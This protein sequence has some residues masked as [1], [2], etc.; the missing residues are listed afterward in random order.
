VGTAPAAPLPSCQ[1]KQ[2]D[3]AATDGG[4]NSFFGGPGPT[5][6]FFGTSAAAPHAA[7]VAALQLDLAPGL[8]PAQVIAAQ[9]ASAR[10]VG[11][12]GPGAVGAGL[13]DAVAA[14]AAH[15]VPSAQVI[16]WTTPPPGSV[17]AG[18]SF[19]VAAAATSGLPVS[20]SSSGQCTGGGTGSATII[21]TTAGACTVRADQAGD[22]QWL[23]AA[24]L[25]ASVQV[26]DAGYVPTSPA[27]LLDSRPGSVTFDGQGGGIG[28]RPALST[29]ELQVTGRAGVPADAGAAVLNVTVT[30][31]DA[32]GFV[33]VWP[34][35]EPRPLA[36]SLNF[37][38]GANVPNNVIV[39]IG[40]GGKVCLYTLAAT[41]LVADLNGWMPT[42]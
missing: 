23:P 6:R 27:R 20:I 10:A 41:H 40:A 7:A 24:Q 13:V 8:T 35:G 33:T 25:A 19:P 2:V 12:F 16:S 4:R 31:P 29:T 22:S 30:E 5:F 28:V 18:T 36:S 3:I 11:S 38:A 26:A 21:A 14:L 9:A 39:K 15:S 17:A 42:N 37:T 1:S 32:P 34:C